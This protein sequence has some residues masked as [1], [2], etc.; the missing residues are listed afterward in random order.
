[1]KETYPL[2]WP[3]G[4]RRT[5]LNDRE[6]R[7]AEII[8]ILHHGPMSTAQISAALHWDVRTTQKHISNMKVA[9][10]LT[11]NGNKFSLSE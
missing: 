1:M 3:E 10:F 9:G 7:P 11:K 8:D 2:V 5:P 4:W 6:A